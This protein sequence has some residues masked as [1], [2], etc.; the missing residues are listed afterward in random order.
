MGKPSTGEAISTAY[1]ERQAGL[2]VPAGPEIRKY[3]ELHEG[4][5]RKCNEV[6]V[7][8]D[9]VL[10]CASEHI[11]G[12]QCLTLNTRTIYTEHVIMHVCMM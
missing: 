11:K 4:I 3:F 9:L 5:Y 2:A 10:V 6:W 1:V 8:L 12:V 7:D